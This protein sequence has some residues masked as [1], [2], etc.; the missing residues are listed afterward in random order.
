[1]CGLRTDDDLL[2]AYQLLLISNQRNQKTFLKILFLWI[3]LR[4][5]MTIV[6]FD[7]ILILIFVT[8]IILT[9][10]AIVV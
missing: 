3:L 9:V 6:V 8:C 5:R 1:M 7:L 10:F 4:H 2:P